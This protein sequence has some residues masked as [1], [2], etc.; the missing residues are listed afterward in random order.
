MKNS[1]SMGSA[2]TPLLNTPPAYG[3]VGKG[4]HPRERVPRLPDKRGFLSGERDFFLCTGKK[5]KRFS[6]NR[7]RGGPLVRK[8]NSKSPILNPPLVRAR[9]EGNGEIPPLALWTEKVPL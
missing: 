6:P 2:K 8:K 9:G 7:K 4:P 5:R 3:S 1:S